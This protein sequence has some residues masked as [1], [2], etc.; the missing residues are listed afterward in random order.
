MDDDAYALP[1]LA[2]RAAQ[3]DGGGEGERRRREG[4]DASRPLE[5]NGTQS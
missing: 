1:G 2:M 4:T 3:K 5:R